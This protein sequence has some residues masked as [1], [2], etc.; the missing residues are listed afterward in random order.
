MDCGTWI[1]EFTRP[2]TDGDYCIANLNEWLVSPA[3]M[4]CSTT[5]Y[6]RRRHGFGGCTFLMTFPLL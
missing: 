4:Q 1:V 5:H 2:L 6:N 3:M